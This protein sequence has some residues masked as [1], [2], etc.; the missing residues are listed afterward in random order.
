MVFGEVWHDYS[1]EK[2]TIDYDNIVLDLELDDIFKSVVFE[3]FIAME[4]IG[5]WDENII[6]SIVVVDD[7]EFIDKALDNI[8]NN[9]STR[10]KGAVKK[11]FN[12]QWKCVVVELIDGVK[13]RILCDNV[14]LG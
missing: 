7:C 3:N 13:I 12:T 2:I 6:K 1:I 14:V 9:N 4:Y 8:K 10:L 11:D 5:Q